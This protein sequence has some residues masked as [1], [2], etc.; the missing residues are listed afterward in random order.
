MRPNPLAQEAAVEFADDL[1]ICTQALE[2]KQAKEEE[3][4]RK[5]REALKRKINSSLQRG[6]M[7][8]SSSENSPSTTS[9]SFLDGPRPSTAPAR[10][11]AGA[12]SN[13]R[14]SAQFQSSTPRTPSERKTRTPR[15]RVIKY[16][17]DNDNSAL[18]GRAG[19]VTVT[20]AQKR[21]SSEAPVVLASDVKIQ[22]LLEEQL[23]L[24]ERC[25]WL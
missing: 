12:S 5:G 7:H 15:D 18:D 23:V 16:N 22:E 4:L 21:N 11:E 14:K 1:D 13:L 2:E 10:R 8:A 6:V 25:V 20:R 17:A 3:E 24:I 19:A 9:S